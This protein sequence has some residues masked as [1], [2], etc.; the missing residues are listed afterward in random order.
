MTQETKNP[1]KRLSPDEIAARVRALLVLTLAG[2]LA[3]IVGGL[4]Y[5]LI[6]VYQPEQMAEADIKM[7]EILSPLTAGIVGA[8][9]GLAA[10][11]AL[12]KS[13]DDE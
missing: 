13:N 5:S 9:T 1:R 11:A 3:F 12:G 4:L 2:V 8:L 7:F 10:G 6:F